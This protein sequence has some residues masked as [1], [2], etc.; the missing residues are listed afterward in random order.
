MS[1]SLNHEQGQRSNGGFAHDA[2]FDW[3]EF[4]KPPD[5][6]VTVRIEHLAEVF[7]DGDL[8]LK[9][10]AHAL[11]TLTGINDRSAYNTLAEGGRFKANLSRK[12]G[13]VCFRR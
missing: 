6:R 2:E 3:A 7:K 9:D 11:A 5:K 13:M 4:D 1:K 10:A 12:Q 8:E